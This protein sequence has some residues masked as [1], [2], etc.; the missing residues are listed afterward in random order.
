MSVYP[1]LEQRVRIKLHSGLAMF[2]KSGIPSTLAMFLKAGTTKTDDFTYI[3]FSG[4][5][6]TVNKRQVSHN[7]PNTVY[8][9]FVKNVDQLFR[10]QTACRIVVHVLVIVKNV[11]NVHGQY[12]Y[13]NTNMI[14]SQLVHHNLHCFK[15]LL[16]V[17][18]GHPLYNLLKSEVL[19]PEVLKTEVLYNLLKSEVLKPKVLKTKVLK[20]GAFHIV[21]QY[22]FIRF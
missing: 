1:T 11:I 20:N 4:N 2:L 19:K 9:H 22:I 15:R 12:R 21:K 18:I 10:V 16:P 17:H 14:F 5:I 7:T 6:H 8:A 3:V 13:I